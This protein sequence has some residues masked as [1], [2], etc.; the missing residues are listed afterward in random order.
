MST[1]NLDDL[2][3][4]LAERVHEAWVRERESQGWTVGPVRSDELKQHPSI[5]PY[6]ELSESEK[7]LDRASV[8]ATVKAI[9]SLGYQVVKND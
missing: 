9:Q 1:F 2:I 4:Q 6:A 3:E 5:K 7:Q 8:R